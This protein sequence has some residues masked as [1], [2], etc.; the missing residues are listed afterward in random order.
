MTLPEPTYKYVQ[1]IQYYPVTALVN[2]ED[3]DDVNIVQLPI[4]FTQSDVEPMVVDQSGIDKT[5]SP[6]SEF[7]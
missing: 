2:Y 3:D 7:F 4:M 6:P 5:I 1:G